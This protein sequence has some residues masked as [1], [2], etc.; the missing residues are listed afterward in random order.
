MFSAGAAA[1]MARGRCGVLLLLFLVL[2]VRV[3]LGGK[4]HGRGPRS[5]C[6]RRRRYLSVTSVGLCGF[7]TVMVTW[8]LP[9]ALS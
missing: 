8:S 6:P 9:G 2:G 7:H 1:A 3:V 4:A 5:G